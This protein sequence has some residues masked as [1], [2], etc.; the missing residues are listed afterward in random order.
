MVRGD[1]LLGQFNELRTGCWLLVHN[2]EAAILEMPPFDEPETDPAELAVR[3]AQELQASVKFLLCT[4]AHG[5]HFDEGTFKLF[6]RDYPNAAIHFQRGLRRRFT[7]RKA[8]SSLTIF[9]N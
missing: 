9:W 2:D 8:S 7:A 4:H 6:R 1:N 5:D 3:A